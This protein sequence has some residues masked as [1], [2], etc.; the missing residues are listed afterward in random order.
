MAKRTRTDFQYVHE[1][2]SD[3][4]VS[5]C[6]QVNKNSLRLGK[7]VHVDEHVR[8]LEQQ[9]SRG[10][11]ALWPVFRIVRFE[12]ADTQKQQRWFVMTLQCKSCSTYLNPSVTAFNHCN[13]HNGPDGKIVYKC[14]KG[15]RTRQYIANNQQIKDGSRDASTPEKGMLTQA[16]EHNRS[17]KS[18]CLHAHRS[19]C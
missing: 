6:E 17:V 19:T 14:F 4:D 12:V 18:C 13:K 2:E 8:A 1:L 15:S 16:A 7:S 10:T 3:T 5:D 9:K 11:A